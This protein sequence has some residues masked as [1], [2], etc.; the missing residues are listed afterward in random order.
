MHRMPRRLDLHS[1]QANHATD[2]DKKQYHASDS[3]ENPVLTGYKPAIELKTL[4][5]HAAKRKSNSA[6]A[7][8]SS[9][10]N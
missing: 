8:Q 7:L 10:A 6:L 1:R 4:H 2:S 9:P 3:R 5:G